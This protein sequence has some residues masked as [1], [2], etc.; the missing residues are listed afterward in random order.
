MNPTQKLPWWSVAIR[1]I[2]NSFHNGSDGVIQKN[3]KNRRLKHDACGMHPAVF[4]TN[5]QL[6]RETPVSVEL[7]L[8]RYA[9]K[10]EEGSPSCEFR[11]VS[12]KTAMVHGIRGCREFVGSVT[13]KP[14]AEPIPPNAT[15]PEF[16]NTNANLSVPWE[17]QSWCVSWNWKVV[18]KPGSGSTVESAAAVLLEMVHLPIATLLDRRLVPSTLFPM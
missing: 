15:G 1:K 3:R 12:K 10:F 18:S 16:C 5:A 8:A 9:M 7:P 11:Q 2:H 4:Q 14:P 6:R 17:S 13:P